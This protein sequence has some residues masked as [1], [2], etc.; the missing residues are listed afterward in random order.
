MCM[1]GG[2]TYNLR[3]AI[4]PSMVSISNFIVKSMSLENDHGMILLRTKT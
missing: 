4:Q 3:N 1:N 2:I